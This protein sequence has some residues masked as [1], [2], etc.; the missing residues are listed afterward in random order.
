MLGINTE[1]REKSGLR[2]LSRDEVELSR[3]KHGQNRLS[4]KKKKSFLKK[5]LANLSDPIIKIL[6]GALAVN[7]LFALGSMNIAETL[8]IVAAIAVSTLVSTM[9]EYASEK[10]FEKLRKEGENEHF[11]VLREGSVSEIHI[12]DIVVGDIVFLSSGEK[13]PADGKVLSGEISIDESALTGESGEVK[14]SRDKENVVYRGSLVTSGQATFAVERVGDATHYGKIASELSEDSR[15]S[16]LK[17]RLS[18]LAKQISYVGYVSAALIAVAY[19]FSDIFIDSA[20]N[21][22]AII[23]KLT[24]LPHVY[25]LL[26]HCLTLAV[27]VIVVCVPEGLPMMITV[28]LS[29]NMRRMM[30]DN[31]LV[32]K[33]VGIETAGSM[34]ILFTDKTGTLTTG[35]QSVCEV[36]TPLGKS[37]VSRRSLEEREETLHT[38]LTLDANYNSDSIVSG[39]NILGGNSV[40]RAFIDFFRDIKKL[41]K[42]TVGRKIPFTSEKKYSA[43]EIICTD[44]YGA[45]RKFCLVRGAPEII[46]SKCSSALFNDKKEIFDKSSLNKKMHEMTSRAVRVLALAICEELPENISACENMIFCALAGVRDSVRRE[47]R[48]AVEEIKGAGVQVVML[49]GDNKDTAE[50]VAR[51]CSIIGKF[52]DSLVISGDELA[53]MSDVEVCEKLPKIAVI[54]RALPGDKSRLVRLS[55]EMGLVV[56]MTGDGVNDA[57]ALKKADVGFAVG[58]GSEVAKEAGDIVIL[59]NNFR[60]IVSAVLYGRTIFSSIRKFITFQL[61][62]N[63][64][65]VAVSLIGPFIGFD[66]PINVIQM[67]WV[68]IIMDTLGGLAFAGEG[69]V[70]DVMR[71]KP[72]KLT[73]GLV[74]R[75]MVSH[76]AFSGICT[77]AICL[78]FMCSEKIKVFYSADMGDNKYLGAFFALFI[79]L[80]IFNCFTARSRRLNLFAN[81]EKNKMFVIIMTLVATIQTFMIYFGGA[82][83]R[84][85]PLSFIEFIYV[86]S[87]AFMIVPLNLVQKLFQ[88]LWKSRK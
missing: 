67:L 71:E 41:P 38:L 34:N 5:L 68:N 20:F 70:K 1:N 87:L 47:A 82:L 86:I 3:K 31:I 72:K 40:D 77:I 16:P 83:F 17:M 24:S 42:V 23:A 88:R 85:S 65:A 45:Q 64:C 60:S 15:E 2:G 9:S 19:F 33:L 18:K 76:I 43:S 55:Q 46:L 29:S 56:G 32:R 4:E 36:V 30:K 84:T 73:E 28:V 48:D 12:D 58:S 35:R 39:G 75:E 22:G 54:A 11:R 49:T 57:P 14:R 61:T 66:S 6:L 25:G 63:L 81:I 51:E 27:T 53:K 7:T 44:K 79:F 74:S 80:G 78:Y 10:A 13:V 26:M 59:D 8:G 52:S 37:Y 50:A 62:M 69:A 21:R